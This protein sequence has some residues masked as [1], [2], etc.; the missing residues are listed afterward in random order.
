MAVS[1]LPPAREMGTEPQ[2]STVGNPR[3]GKNRRRDAASRRSICECSALIDRPTEPRA[4]ALD[5]E[6]STLLRR[7]MNRDGSSSEDDHLLGFG[8]TSAS[9]DSL[10]SRMR[11]LARCVAGPKTCG[12][13]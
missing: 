7:P 11:Q 2:A 9:R 3:P 10:R 13:A 6:Q 12:A 1:A 5:L 8:H 4:R